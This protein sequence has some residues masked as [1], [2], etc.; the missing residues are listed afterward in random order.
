MRALSR[1]G[2]WALFAKMLVKVRSGEIRVWAV[3]PF[4]TACAC[5]ARWTSALRIKPFTA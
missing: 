4:K 2:F 3:T 1:W 5:Q